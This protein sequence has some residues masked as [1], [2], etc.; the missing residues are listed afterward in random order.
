MESHRYTASW[1]GILSPVLAPV[2]GV[3]IWAALIQALSSLNFLPQSHPAADPDQT[4]FRYKSDIVRSKSCGNMI[5]I[6]DSSCTTGIDPVQLSSLLP[7]R[8]CVLNLG[9]IIGLSL[10]TLASP[11]ATFAESNPDQVRWIILLVTPQKLKGEDV[12][13]HHEEMWERL[14]AG[15]PTAPEPQSAFEAVAEILGLAAA[16]DRIVSHVLHRPMDGAAAEFYGFAAGL[17]DHL[18]RRLGSFVDPGTYT[19]PLGKQKQQPDYFI[20]PELETSSRR[21]RTLLPPIVKLAVAIMPVPEGHADSSYISK[22]RRLLMEWNEWLNADLVLTNLPARLP[23]GLFAS[24]A[25]L[26]G[27]GQKFFTSRLAEELQRNGFVG[28]N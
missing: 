15:Q 19:R 10:D 9:L 8:P 25:H 16:R 6:G 17:S 18:T 5:L 24:G 27:A 12:G 4:L 7:E 28:K 11:V 2:V 26:N 20:S 3:I 22:H 14:Q 21:L 23:D 1:R 13:E